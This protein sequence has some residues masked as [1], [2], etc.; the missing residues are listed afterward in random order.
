MR[1]AE[2]LIVATHGLCD[3][4]LVLKQGEPFTPVVLRVHTDPLSIVGK[5][6]EQNPKSYTNIQSLLAIAINI[7]DAGLTV[8]DKAGKSALTP[9]QAPLQRAMAERRVTAMCIDAALNEDDFETAYSYV[10]SRLAANAESPTVTAAA[11]AATSSAA[12]QGVTVDTWSWRAAL[13]AGKYRRTERTVRPTHLGTASANLEIRH[14][15]QRIECLATALRIAPSDTLQEILNAY[16]R[17]EEE[18]EAAVKAEDEQE[19]AWD[20]AADQSWQQQEAADK[21]RRRIR[22]SSGTGMPGSFADLDGSG[23]PSRSNTPLASRVAA[24]AA[25]AATSTYGGQASSRSGP[26]QARKQPQ[27]HQRQQS[28]SA[29]DDA[30]LSLFDLSRATARAASRNFSALSSLR[31]TRQLVGLG[32]GSGDGDDGSSSHSRGE[33]L[34]DDDQADGSGPH[35]RKRDQLR[36]AAMGTLTSGVG[37]LIGAQPVDR[38]HSERD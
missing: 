14:L 30:P 1:R 24:A 8:R 12:N 35:V 4:R 5:V 37:W 26:G 22:H 29:T 15:E 33:S 17:C 2:A 34:H 16:R 3:Y 23:T 11:A 32:G 31:Q 38:V 9:E 21:R 27:R 7:V 28:A 20:E 6:L 19:N 25:A 13:E 18:L 10:M 36:D